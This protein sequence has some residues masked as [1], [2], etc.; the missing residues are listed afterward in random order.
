MMVLMH[1]PLVVPRKPRAGVSWEGKQRTGKASEEED[2]MPPQDDPTQGSVQ[3]YAEQWTAET[4]F[5]QTMI[6]AI[7]I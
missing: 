5:L 1:A 6:K 3:T 2:L 4:P 7:S